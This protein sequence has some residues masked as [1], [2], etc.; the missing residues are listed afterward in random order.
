[1]THV[2]Q[3]AQYSSSP[4]SYLFFFYFF[5][6]RHK[7]K[8]VNIILHLRRYERLFFFEDFQPAEKCSR[9]VEFHKSLSLSFYPPPPPYTFFPGPCTLK[10]PPS[11]LA[12]IY[13]SPRETSVFTF[14]VVVVTKEQKKKHGR[15]KML[16]FFFFTFCM[17]Q[18]RQ[19]WN[20]A[21]GE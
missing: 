10:I 8:T 3:N 6:T 13:W 20:W 4:L 17:E 14:F 18:L 16:C 12:V 1:M 15:L 7:E 2:E 9:S 21:A 11:E 19:P 5:F